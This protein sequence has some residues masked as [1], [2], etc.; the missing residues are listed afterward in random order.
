FPDGPLGARRGIV[1]PGESP[2]STQDGHSAANSSRAR[3]PRFTAIFAAT[4]KSCCLVAPYAFGERAHGRVPEP[5]PG[6]EAPIKLKTAVI[7]RSV[8][9]LFLKRSD[10]SQRAD[11]KA[12]DPSRATTPCRGAGLYGDSSA[13]HV[14]LRTCDVGR[15]IGSQEQNGVRHLVNL[16]RPPHRNDP[17][18]FGPHGGIG[19]A[20]GCAHR[21]HD[22][23]MNRV[24]ADLVLCVL[25]RD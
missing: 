24:G 18:P 15:L 19:G 5:D 13:V 2:K 12:A 10:P 8:R 16:S 25:H 3:L 6:F 7:A 1:K 14:D 20:T 17:H 22:A 23:G 4:T 9:A 21:R 11:D